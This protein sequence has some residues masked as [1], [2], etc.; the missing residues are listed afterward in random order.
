MMRNQ[1]QK[2]KSPRVETSKKSLNDFKDSMKSLR[3]YKNV[4]GRIFKSLCG[5][6]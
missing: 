6:V 2:S 4:K 1:S 5:V 3:K